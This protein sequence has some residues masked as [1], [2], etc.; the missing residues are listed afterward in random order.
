MKKLINKFILLLCFCLIILVS[1]TAFAQSGMQIFVRTTVG[2]TI[3]LDVESSDSIENLKTKVQDKLGVPPDRQSLYFAGKLLMDD[4]TLADYNIQK[5]STIYLFVINPGQMTVTHKREI[6]LPVR[7]NNVPQLALNDSGLGATDLDQTQEVSGKQRFI[8]MYKRLYAMHER[9]DGTAYYG[10]VRQSDVEITLTAII[11]RHINTSGSFPEEATLFGILGTNLRYNLMNHQGQVQARWTTGLPNARTIGYGGAGTSIVCTD[12]S[13][14]FN[15]VSTRLISINHSSQQS[16]SF[17][18]DVVEQTGKSIGGWMTLAYGAD[19]L[20]YLFDYENLRILKFDTGVR[21]GTRGAF[22]GTFDLDPTKPAVN[23]MTVDAAGNFYVGSDNGGFHIYGSD[24]QWKQS[25]TGIYQTDPNSDVP[26]LGAIYKPYMNYYASGLNDGNGTLD[27][28][29]ATGYR[30]YTI[31]APGQTPPIQIMAEP[32][33]QATCLLSPTNLS[34]IAAADDGA[35]L[36]YQWRKN[37]VALTDGGTI[38]GATTAN[39]NISSTVSGD[40]GYYDVLV[41]KSGAIV[42]SHAAIITVTPTPI[43]TQ[44]PADQSLQ[45]SDSATFTATADHSPG[46]QWQVST[47]GGAIFTDVSGATNA[48]LSIPSVDNSHIGNYY[49]AVFTPLCG[50]PVISRAAALKFSQTITFANPGA[51]TFGDPAFDLGAAASSGLTVSYTVVFGPATV[52]GSML[53]LTNSGIVS[54]R[55]SQIGDADYAAAPDVTQTF[56]VMRPGNAAAPYTVD[57]ISDDVTL[58]ACTSAP[59]D[60][61]LRAAVLIANILASD[62]SINFDSSLAGQTIVLNSINASYA[63]Q[64]N[65]ADNGKLTINGLG[66]SQLSISGNTASRVFFIEE[67]AVAAINNLT[68]TGGFGDGGYDNG[69]GGGI[70]NLTGA[71]T[72]TDVIVSGNSAPNGGGIYSNGGALTLDRSIVSI[73]STGGGRGGGIFQIDGTL[74]LT[75]STVSDNSTI[76][77]SGNGAGS[78]GG[79]FVWN[80]ATTLTDSTV[81]GNR[82]QGTLSGGGGGGI[83]VNHGTTTLTNSTF[84]DNRAGG[85]GG[86]YIADLSSGTTTL[87]NTTVTENL[88][89][90]GIGEFVNGGG[91][92]NAGTSTVTVSNCIIAKNGGSTL[93]VTGPFVSGGYNLIGYIFT[94]GVHRATGFGATGDKFGTNGTRIEAML[95]P[96]GF[97][98]GLT[99]THALA[100]D[101]PAIDAGNGSLTTDQHGF[102]RPFDY[103][104]VTD[105]AGGNSADIGAVEMQ[106]SVV[107][108]TA[109]N[110]QPQNQI[111]CETASASFSVGATGAN[112]N[113][114]WRKGGVNL[115]DGAAISGATSANLNINSAA[116]SDTGTYDVLVTGDG[117]T[118]VSGAATLGVNS[119]PVITNQPVNQNAA[120]G[121]A[122][123]FTAAATGAQTVQWQ[124]STGAGAAFSDIGGANQSMLTLTAVNPSQNG[125]QYRAIFT[126]ACGDPA[127]S[128]AATLII[129]EPADLTVTK[130]HSGDFTQGDTGK[131]YSMTVSNNGSGATSGSVS[132]TDSL[133]DGLTATSMSGEG[134]NCN[135]S[136]L[137]CTRSDALA[138]N[139]SYPAI[140]LTVNVAADA[141]GSVTNVVSVSGG[142]E[143]D[144]G[145]NQAAD[146]TTINAA[147][148][149]SISGTVRYGATN[150]GQPDTFVTGVSLDV[151]GSE[152]SSTV[153]DD[154]GIYQLS[155]LAGGNYTVTPSKIG[156]VKGINSLDASRI[157]QHLVGLTTLTPNQLIAAD[158]DNNGVVNSLDA[159]RIQQYLVQISSENIIG[160]WKFVP[161]NR[162]YNALADNASGQDYQAVLV[163]EVSGNWSSADSFADDSETEEEL[164]PQQENL[165][166]TVDGFEQ[167]LSEQIAERMKQSSDLQSNS[168]AMN[169][170]QSESATAGASTPVSLPKISAAVGNTIII[171]VSIGA[172]PS[173]SAIES[174]DFSVFYDPAILQPANPAG[175]NAGTL[176]ANCSMLANAPAAGRVAVSGACAQAFTNNSGGVLY[177][178]TFT[179]I[180][181]NG[182][183]TALSFTNPA[184]E[185]D[186]F[187]FNNGSPNAQAT[188]GSFSASFAPTAASVSVSGRVTIAS[189]RGIRNVMITMTDSAGNQRQIQTTGFGYY[190]FDNVTAGEIVTISAKTRRYKFNQSSI[191]KTTNE[192][193]TDADF[194][195]EP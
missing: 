159:A 115:T 165:N 138:A 142:G 100:D 58:S 52:A 90:V 94:S 34:V 126:G 153:S 179:V 187:Q 41:R 12:V 132:V 44:Q 147:A 46:V 183:Q 154:D 53:T 192:S 180:G 152:S 75:D 191:V 42:T 92:Y 54:I 80:N 171:P 72:L 186:T 120:P 60:C 10:G 27:V 151:T 83:F 145:N 18:G 45:I 3:T 35:P 50:A 119:A 71:L 148:T 25:I 93:D 96:L 123:S 143:T 117:G 128:N 1:A 133:P 62:E 30:Q 14:Q 33:G 140:T 43:I 194:V 182:R 141:P 91:V 175:N 111:V 173:G 2:Q 190:R 21:G 97:Y 177:K 101:S 114:Q 118:V 121:G 17:S 161:G 195:S 13:Y 48:T 85:G 105:A 26:S 170:P 163:G 11:E 31:T 39:L 23:S 131:T 157:Q 57:T 135:F 38:S 16:T 98:G 32:Q 158:V 134:W 65:I 81:S 47:D 125:S 109:I 36:T 169:K 87:T 51:K 110:T 76:N 59:N 84:S 144:T 64:L 167:E 113:Y 189:G 6:K 67:N 70:Y 24:G 160:Q 146:P 82:A 164:L 139:S 137:T 89:K 155:N 149:Y 63:G 104:E 66:L 150:V 184:T 49:R 162:Q 19:D 129:I 8:A 88:N 181:M 4:R 5:E 108:V 174:F 99:K 22:L 40:A 28:R 69:S 68:V 185:I 95:L 15:G 188:N 55:A 9:A 193:V 77:G 74:T 78:G 112:L 37:A 176:S 86:V 102:S 172:N 178:L 127:T 56:T 20:L 136:N 29:D 166:E 79:I 106:P 124:I 107:L 7:L 130:T 103:P 73:N 61:S 122:A 116:L 156:E 168:S